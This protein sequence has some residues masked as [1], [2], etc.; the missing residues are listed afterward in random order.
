MIQSKQTFHFKPPI[1]IEGSWMIGLTGLEV[2]NSIFN[3][4][5]QNNKLQLYK[6]PDEKAGGVSYGKVKDEIEKD[7]DISDITATDLQDDIIG[8]TIIKEYR[9]QVTK[10]MKDD[11]YMNILAIYIDSVF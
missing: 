9:E 11:K 8:P 4:T 10:R 2:Y 7:L 5:E 3:I 1:P 6:F